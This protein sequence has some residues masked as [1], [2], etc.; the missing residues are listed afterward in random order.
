MVY[1][2]KKRMERNDSEAFLF[3]FGC[4]IVGRYGLPKDQQ[5]AFN[6][7]L[8]A[9][10]LG[11]SNACFN[12]ANLYKDGVGVSTDFVKSMKYFK[13]SAKKENIYARHQLGFDEFKKRKSSCSISALVTLG[14]CWRY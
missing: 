2:V 14:S 4:Y 5:Q 6:L 8:R 1:R 10:E 13:E 12:V 11:N 7:C 3:I 9:A